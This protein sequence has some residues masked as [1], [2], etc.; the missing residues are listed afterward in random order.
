MTYMSENRPSRRD[1]NDIFVPSGDHDGVESKPGL[2]VSLTSLEPSTFTAYI[3]SLPSRKD[4]KTI[5]EPSGEHDGQESFAR[6]SVSLLT[7]E[8][9]A[10]IT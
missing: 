10:F 7:P 4:E 8:P 5:R 1:S 2:S 9:S 6:W 3:S